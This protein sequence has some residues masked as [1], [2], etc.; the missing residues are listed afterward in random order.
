MKTKQTKGKKPNPVCKQ[1]LH[2]PKVTKLKKE[3]L[4]ICLNVRD[5]CDN[6]MEKSDLD[7]MAPNGFPKGACGDMSLILQ[8][9]IKERLKIDCKRVYGKGMRTNKQIPD[10]QHAWLIF[11]DINIDITADQFQMYQLEKISKVIVSNNSLFHNQFTKV[12]VKDNPLILDCI[13]QSSADLNLIRCADKIKG[14]M[15][16]KNK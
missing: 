15:L 12:E 3:I 2:S 11:E 10:A 16:E 1:F 8:L 9:I 7:F 13:N 6:K 14:L 5:V 4:D